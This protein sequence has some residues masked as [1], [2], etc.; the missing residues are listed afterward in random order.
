MRNKEKEAFFFL[1][2]V[3][4]SLSSSRKVLV[5]KTA[6]SSQNQQPPSIDSQQ[7]QGNCWS[8]Y[9]LFS[10]LYARSSS[11]RVLRVCLCVC[12]CIRDRMIT[13]KLAVFRVLPLEGGGSSN[14]RARPSQKRNG[15]SWMSFAFC[16][17]CY[18]YALLAD[19]IYKLPP[20][21]VDPS[22]PSCDAPRI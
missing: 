21:D 8:V 1:L 3:F 15:R 4:S 2:S 18:Y 17:H 12:E 5:Y 19:V 16:P 7:L 11:S 13:K 20:P 10:L 22:S 9:I 6:S 14:S